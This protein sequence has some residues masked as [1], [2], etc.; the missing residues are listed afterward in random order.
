MLAAL[1]PLPV[2]CAAVLVLI[3]G[4]IISRSRFGLHLIAIGASQESALLGG[5]NTGRVVLAAYLLS[6]FFACLGGLNLAARLASGDPLVGASF[7]IDSIAAT[8]L[9]GTQLS[10][11][12]G[13]VVGP[14]TGVLFLALLGN[15]LNLLNIS[16]YYQM[17]IKGVLLIVAVSA[18]RR[19]QPGL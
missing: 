1:L 10:G 4:A 6:S 8:A 11:G 12:L 13:G 2:I 9:G 7:A 5:V 17:I 14:V 18:H 16:T 3:A 19:K 15:G